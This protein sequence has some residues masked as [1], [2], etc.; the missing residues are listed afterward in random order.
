[1][2]PT[3]RLSQSRSQHMSSLNNP[4]P[5]DR[6]RALVAFINAQEIMQGRPADVDD[7]TAEDME[8]KVSPD[9][10]GGRILI[11]YIDNHCPSE[12]FAVLT[13]EEAATAKE[14]PGDRDYSEDD[15]VTVDGV[16]Y[17]VVYLG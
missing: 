7:R 9:H 4:T 15:C 2:L 10:V 5:A 6:I 14:L 1:M 13:V 11:A 16:E 12:P 17:L 8:I 3:G